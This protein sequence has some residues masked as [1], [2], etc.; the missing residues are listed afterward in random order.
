MNKQK[1]KRIKNITLKRL[2]SLFL[3]AV[4][5]FLFIPETISPVVFEAAVPA[6]SEL[7]YGVYYK[8]DDDHAVVTGCSDTA[9][10]ITISSEYNGYPVTEIANCAFKNKTSLKKVTIANSVTSIG[11]G[12]F[13]GC[14]GLT[15]VDI[16]DI[17]KWC[18]IE[19]YD[20]DANPLI[21]AH[22]LYLNGELVTDLVI[23]YGI[24]SI[25][26]L[27]LIGCTS[28]TSVTIADSVTS[29]G[30]G[31]FG[32]CTGI[33]SITIP[34]SV[35]SI[36]WWAFGGC[37]SLE[38]VEITDLAKWYAIDFGEGANPMSEG[39]TLYLNGVKVDDS[40]LPEGIERI[41]SYYFYGRSDIT[42]I[43]IPD[44]VTSIGRNAFEGCTGLTS[45]TISDSVTSI[46]ELAFYG[47]TGLT[48]IK[49]PDSVTS[50]GELAF[51]NCTGLTNLII[52]NN[53]TEIEF[54]TFY[55]C[56]GLTSIII[57]SGVTYIGD[58]AFQAC[59]GLVSIKIPDTVIDIGNW[60]FSDCDI[61]E[62]IE[63][64]DLRK[65]Y[66]IDFGQFGNPLSEGIAS[67]YINGTKVSNY[68]IPV[69]AKKIGDCCFIDRT[70]I[71]NIILPNTVTSIGNSAFCG[72]TGLTSITIPDSVTNIDFEAFYGCENLTIKTT[73]GSYADIYAQENN[74]PVQYIEIIIGDVNGDGVVN[75]K[76]R[77][78]LT[79][80][81][82]KWPEAL[83]EGINEA[84]ADVN[85]DG[86][87]NGQD[88][89]ILTRHLAR[90]TEYAT[91]PYIK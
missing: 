39:A 88:R 53:I 50:I 87:I 3:A 79:R 49:I 91:L 29:I 24:T 66:E 6:D 40:N 81:L 14:T 33:T 11:W 70:D 65:W 51:R 23:P 73:R 48:S 13:L 52:S 9:T 45:I 61:L 27:A 83:A 34:D 20:D 47:C 22:N 82:A 74:I 63:I 4:F 89:L 78:L 17:A 42:S 86:K 71:T 25:G 56:K 57:P 12:A 41:G 18:A 80:W 21:Y 62:R 43:K 38:R 15:R 72:C 31:A 55:G 77:L 60:T 16:N 85:C 46:G 35:T 8:I 90:W 26:H 67:L 5:M 37:T 10:E 76:D 69:G 58:C 64:S 28:L 19:F 2:I 7:V 54:M 44:S 36:G 30:N 32:G 84:A 1:S 59:S 75:G 68:N